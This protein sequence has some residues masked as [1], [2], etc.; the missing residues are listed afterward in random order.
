MQHLSQ[1][2][3]TIHQG[4]FLRPFVSYIFALTSLKNLQYFLVWEHAFSV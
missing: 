1:Y 3:Q 2:K 4:L